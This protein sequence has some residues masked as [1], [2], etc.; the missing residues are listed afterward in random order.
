M[1]DVD[2]P[3]PLYL[4]H[5]EGNQRIQE[6]RDAMRENYAFWRQYTWEVAVRRLYGQSQDLSER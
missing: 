5:T 4:F 6:S 3:Q 2:K 1:D